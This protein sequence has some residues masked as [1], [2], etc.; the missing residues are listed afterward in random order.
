M[1]VIALYCARSECSLAQNQ[2]FLFIFV[3][4]NLRLTCV[5]PVPTC[6]F[7]RHGGIERCDASIRLL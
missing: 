4:M 7:G 5:T 1:Q 6:T 3:Y 2:V